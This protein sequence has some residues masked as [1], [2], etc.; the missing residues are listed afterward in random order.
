MECT[1]FSD[2]EQESSPP[3]SSLPVINALGE[4]DDF[5]VAAHNYLEADA[6]EKPFQTLFLSIDPAWSGSG[7]V[8]VD[9]YC[10]PEYPVLCTLSIL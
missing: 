9:A 4:K 5:L 1:F 2:M 10:S 6:Q 8:L 7:C 3:T